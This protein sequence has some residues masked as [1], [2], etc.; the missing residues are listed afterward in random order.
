V[1]SNRVAAL[2]LGWTAPVPAAASSVRARSAQGA[3]PSVVKPSSASRSWA[4]ASG[5]PQPLAVQE[6]GSGP[7]E[8]PPS[9]GVQGERRSVV[10]LG[11]VAWGEQGPAPVGDRRRPWLAAGRGPGVEA[12]ERL[13]CAGRLVQAGACLDVVGDGEGD[14]HGVAERAVEDLR[15]PLGHRMVAGT[16]EVE[17]G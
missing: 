17:E 1:S 13:R 4:P 9:L 8:G 10:R 3:A 15:H 6:L 14:D 12:G 2:G 5:P 7:F 16:H 11:L